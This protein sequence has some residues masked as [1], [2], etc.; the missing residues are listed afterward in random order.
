MQ[1]PKPRQN[2]SIF[3]DTSISVHASAHMT[4][5]DEDML[6]SQRIETLEWGVLI[7]E[8]EHCFPFK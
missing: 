7:E 4:I 3:P 2:I 1:T 5:V 6:S 8:V